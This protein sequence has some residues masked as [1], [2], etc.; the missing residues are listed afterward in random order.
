MTWMYSYLIWNIGPPSLMFHRHKVPLFHSK[1]FFIL[2]IYRLIRV[3]A[4]HSIVSVV[5]ILGCP[6]WLLLSLF[7]KHDHTSKCGVA[8]FIMLLAIPNLLCS[9]DWLTH[10]R[11]SLSLKCKCSAHF[12]LFTMITIFL[13]IKHNHAPKCGV[14]WFII[15][16]L[17]KSCI[18]KFL[19]RIILCLAM[20][21]L[22]T[23]IKRFSSVIL[24]LD[25][26]SAMNLPLVKIILFKYML[27]PNFLET[28]QSS[29]HA[30][31]S[32]Q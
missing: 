12:G 1:A 4:I 25:Y 16:E 5:P 20:C 27:S 14:T 30:S 10:S 28:I 22:P 18:S 11:A 26:K 15:K 17:T 29:R 21:I 8:W 2:L 7:I 24:V 32:L 13:F 23:L 9:S 3:L 6:Q 31:H 19:S